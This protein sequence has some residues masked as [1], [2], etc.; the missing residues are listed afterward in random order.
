MRKRLKRVLNTDSL[1][2]AGNTASLAMI[3]GADMITQL[4]VMPRIILKLGLEAYG[5]IAFF[6][7][8]MQ[9]ITFV[10]DFGYNFNATKRISEN[11]DD[12]NI[13][14]V[15]SAIVPTKSVI[16]AIISGLILL[17]SLI[18]KDALS[19]KLSIYLIVFT[20]FSAMTVE[21][22]Y[23]GLQKMVVL[24]VIKIVYR[25]FYVLYIYLQLETGASYTDV[26]FL[27]ALCPVIV[28]SFSLLFAVRKFRLRFVR[29]DKDFSIT[30]FK[31]S[32]VLF[33]SSVFITFYR[34]INVIL[35]KLISGEFY[36]GIYAAIEKI[37]RASQAIME[38]VSTALF[39]FVGKKFSG[40]H[41]N[42]EKVAMIEKLLVLYIPVLCLMAFLIWQFTP[43]IMNYMKIDTPDASQNLHIMLIAFISGCLNYLLGYVGLVNLGRNR[44]FRGAVT[45]TG[46]ISLV[47]SPVSI[48]FFDDLGAV[49]SIAFLEFILLILIGIRFRR[50]KSLAE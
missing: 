4:L 7:V 14:S 33:S 49:M 32:W 18:F 50:I 16:M 12:N 5:Q 2:L 28:T 34:N 39:P 9:Y 48:A 21:W 38:P 37:I 23:L 17:A 47:L 43:Q 25:V 46:C 1:S 24:A 15:F 6:C 35:L 29:V 44:D 22:L 27:D 40:M 10:C 26:I 41:S 30:L 19:F 11:K 13:S 8:I 31:E 3:K 36:A 42:R 45:V 20:I